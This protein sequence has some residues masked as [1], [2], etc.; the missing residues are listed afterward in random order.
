VPS[1]RCSQNKKLL[2][3]HQKIIKKQLVI[4]ETTTAKPT[5]AKK[6]GLKFLVSLFLTITVLLNSFSNCLVYI[7]FKINQ[8]KIAKTLCVLR[9]QKNNTCNGNCVLRAELK[10]QAESEKK[11]T[12]SLKEKIEIVYT[13]IATEYN[14]SPIITPEI[15]KPENFYWLAKPK[16]IVFAVFHPP[17]V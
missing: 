12:T 7:T 5:F 8:D 13:T 17:T 9:A 14:F 10:K 11:Q 6:I 3:F 15:A 1:R 4:L 16:S 2:F